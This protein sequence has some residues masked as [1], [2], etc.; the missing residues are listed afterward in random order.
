LTLGEY[1]G[2]DEGSVDGVTLGVF[3]GPIEG[4][5]LGVREGDDE[6]FL[7]GAAL[8]TSDGLA[9]GE[10]LGENDGDDEGMV[11]GVALGSF[12]GLSE[13][14]G[15]AVGEHEESTPFAP[16]LPLLL[17]PPFVSLHDPFDKLYCC[18]P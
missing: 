5:S 13:G 2:K 11:E 16:A 9:E 3:D 12:D 4:I 7:D 8:G 6:G 15:D 1:E 14:E 18:V 10:A 17:F